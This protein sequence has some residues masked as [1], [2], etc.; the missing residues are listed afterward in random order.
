[1]I[2]QTGLEL[3]RGSE[4]GVSQMTSKMVSFEQLSLEILANSQINT[5]FLSP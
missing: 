2:S 5:G 4:K 3:E 1:M